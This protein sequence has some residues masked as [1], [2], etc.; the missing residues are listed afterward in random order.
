M[1]NPD[2]LEFGTDGQTLVIG[3]AEAVNNR[4]NSSNTALFWVVFLVLAAALV[5]AIA[6]LTKRRSKQ[7]NA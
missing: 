4:E 5:I 1:E 2:I 7:T 6:V 3:D